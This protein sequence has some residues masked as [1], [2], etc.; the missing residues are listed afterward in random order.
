ML[1]VTKKNLMN[2]KR[3]VE[4]IDNYIDSILARPEMYSANISSL[5]DQ[6]H[7]LLNMR[8]FFLKSNFILRN[9]YS[10]TIYNHFGSTCLSL[11]SLCKD[12]EQIVPILLEL[13]NSCRI[14][15]QDKI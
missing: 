9:E 1:V 13:V 3:M 14:K 5:D 6:I 2:N 15:M 7:L 4:Y 11:S 12:Y 10:K 8:I